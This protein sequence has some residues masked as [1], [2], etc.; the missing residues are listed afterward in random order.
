MLRPSTTSLPCPGA[1]TLGSIITENI[2]D[3]IDKKIMQLNIWSIWHSHMCF[4]MVYSTLRT[5]FLLLQQLDD[6]FAMCGSCE[7][8][9]FSDFRQK[10]VKQSMACA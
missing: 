7:I 6:V 9:L 10:G 3:N 5:I 4:P 2:C 8:I 1:L